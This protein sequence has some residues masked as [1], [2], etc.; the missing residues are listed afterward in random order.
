[1]FLL[2]QPMSASPR[3]LAAQTSSRTGLYF[4]LYIVSN[5]GID[6]VRTHLGNRFRRIVG[7]ALFPAWPRH[8]RY[9]FLG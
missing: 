1:M 4:N 9:Y 8:L 7:A 2:V 3:M 6:P 5:T